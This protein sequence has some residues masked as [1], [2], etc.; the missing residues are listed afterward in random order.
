MTNTAYL[1]Q[2]A[3]I[4]LFGGSWRRELELI[5]RHVETVDVADGAVVA[6][7]DAPGHELF[8]IAEGSVVASV[9]GRAVA[10]LGPGD[11]FG[12][13]P[14]LAGSR[15]PAT[16]T[17][18]GPVRVV[19]I[20]RRELLGLLQAVPGLARRLL[21]EMAARLGKHEDP[22]TVAATDDPSAALEP[23]SALRA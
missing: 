15:H 13:G 6:E 23:R 4:P 12:E 22:G 1:E 17:A 8:V 21:R 18:V 9:D 10:M 3:G 7:Q 2:L 19:V 14:T 11:W 16:V 5:A 20:S